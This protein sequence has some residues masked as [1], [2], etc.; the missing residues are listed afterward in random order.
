MVKPDVDNI[1]KIYLDALN[2]IA[3]NDD[4]QVVSI[5]CNKYYS[6][7]PYVEIEITELNEND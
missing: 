3:Y 4:N 2:K 6:D 5:I 7:R 1:I